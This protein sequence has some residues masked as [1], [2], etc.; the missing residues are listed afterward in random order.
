M[1]RNSEDYIRLQEI[2]L[3]AVDLPLGERAAFLKEKC[4]DDAGLRQEV[5][6]LIAFDGQTD[7]FT[8]QVESAIPENLFANEESEPLVGRHFGAYQIVREIGR[9]GL[10]TVYLA[11]RADEEYRKEVAIKVVRRGLDTEDILQ[12]FRHERQI[13]AQL[14]HPNI[15]RLID[16]GTTEDGQPYFVMDYVP[17]ATLLEFCA[18]ENLDTDAR[19]R[20]FRKVCEAVSYAHRNLVIHRDLKPS[21]I[22]VTKEGTPVLLDFGIAK[23]L[24]SDE[25]AFT[26]TIPALRV[27][28]PVYA[29]PEQVKGDRITTSSDVY[30]L[31]VLLYELL[32]G[33]KPYRLTST[34]PDE[35]SRAI[36]GQEPT[37]PSDN[38]PL[39]LRNQQSL[40]GDL[41]NIILMAL[42]KEPERRYASAE[43]FSEDIR[44][45][46]EGLPV[47]ARQDTFSYRAQKFVQ[48][49][50]IGVAAAAIVFLTLV[51][52]IVVTL[53]QAERVVQERNRARKEATKAERINTFLQDV[54]AFSDPSWNSSNPNRDRDAT[55]AEA[56]DMAGRRVETELADQPDVA[57]AVHFTVG[58]TYKSM[59]KLDQAEKHLR[60]A[61]EIRRRELG[62]DDQET[63]QAMIGV[64]ELEMMRGKWKEAEALNRGAVAIYRRAQ[65]KEEVDAKWFATALSNVGYILSY[66]KRQEA[67]CEAL[68]R[69][70]IKVSASLT[71]MDRAPIP[72][73]YSNL[74][75][76]RN[77]QGDLD[78]AAAYLQK[79][80]EEHRQH[81]GDSRRGMGTTLNNLGVLFLIKGDLAAAETTLREALDIDLKTLGE[82]HQFTAWVFANLA[83][84]YNQKGE[85][86]RARNE[87]R[88]AFEIQERVLPADHADLLRSLVP[89]GVALT[90]LGEVAEAETYL[91]RAL[92]IG[93]QKLPEGDRA[94]ASAK[95]ALGENLQAQKRFAEAGKFLSASYEEMKL[96]YGEGHPDT[97]R[98]A[99]R[100]RRFDGAAS[101]KFGN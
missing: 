94:I 15:A 27:M 23:L 62:K 71:G 46:L 48:R 73:F 7:D 65:E 18:A 63:A 82:N 31:G 21:N 4:G 95:G 70:A 76:T 59:G 72:I 35:V 52:G 24:T 93:R 30:S 100:L 43:R 16:G 85:Y 67:E 41:D 29:S 34:K 1:A 13:L 20:L 101:S 54:L 57:A 96:R 45:H 14:D 32:T 40:K 36:T 61:L 42:R 86:A 19:L 9:G 90:S 47:S 6:A 53:V 78:G 77:A 92:E 39:E 49:N 22:L 56:L 58:W 91:R 80:I 25:D 79:S 75:M 83:N 38:R 10:G 66:T 68:F 50:K 81:P 12:R 87:A 33:R 89:L 37:R 55:V 3:A 60:A 64:G 28:T 51:G 8:E 11:E 97:I 69:E 99:E 44:R 98:A 26:Q 74:A 2:F 17:G 5:E 88:H 84:V